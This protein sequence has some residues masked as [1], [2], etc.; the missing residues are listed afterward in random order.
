MRINLLVL[1]IILLSACNS[2]QKTA[3]QTDHIFKDVTKAEANGLIAKKKNLVFLDV[4]TDE[5]IAKGHINGAVKIDFYQ[6][7]FKEELNK[8]DKNTPYLV[9]CRSGGRSGK[10]L[11]IM[12]NQGF[13]EAYNLLGGYSEWKE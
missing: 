12:Q 11:K 9:Y 4:R 13:V 5:E 7:N 2:N 1:S 6:G 10:T 8:L 3:V